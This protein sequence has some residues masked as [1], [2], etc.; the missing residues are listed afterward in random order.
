MVYRGKVVSLS[1]HKC[2]MEHV[3][4]IQVIRTSSFFLKNIDLP[5]VKSVQNNK[6]YLYDVFFFFGRVKLMRL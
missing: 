3:S 6:F 2:V 4:I 1:N 5:N